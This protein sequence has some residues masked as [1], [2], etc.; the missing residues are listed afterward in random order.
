L[1]AG[2]SATAAGAAT[3][4]VSTAAVVATAAIETKKAK[5]IRV[6]C[7]RSERNRDQHG[8]DSEQMAH[9]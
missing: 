5:N 3:A 1:L 2:A 8:S 4:V 9:R 7:H 6:R